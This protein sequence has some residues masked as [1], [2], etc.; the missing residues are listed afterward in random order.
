MAVTSLIPLT[1]ASC[2]LHN[3]CEI[4]NNN[5]LPEWE[6]VN[7]SSQEPVVHEDHDIERRDAEDVR[8]TL[9]EYFLAQQ[10]C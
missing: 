10:A 8:G 2:I 7:S 3:L 6:E 9:A 4:Q 5:F 1:K